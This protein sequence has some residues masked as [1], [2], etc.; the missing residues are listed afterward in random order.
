MPVYSSGS[1]YYPAFAQ[2]RRLW[3]WWAKNRQERK[4]AA[5]V[6]KT[7]ILLIWKVKL[8][9]RT[10]EKLDAIL[11]NRKAIFAASDLT[12]SK[13]KNNCVNKLFMGV[14]ILWA[15][16]ICPAGCK[17]ADNLPSV[18]HFRTHAS[19]ERI[20]KT[21]ISIKETYQE[22]SADIAGC[23]NPRVC[24]KIDS[25]YIFVVKTFMNYDIAVRLQLVKNIYLRIQHQYV[26]VRLRSACQRQKFRNWLL[27]KATL[28][29]SKNCRAERSIS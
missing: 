5:S 21:V 29:W 23:V 10:S 2:F 20:W 24:G 9:F 3:L 28:D 15:I 19:S 12:A 16:I 17:R 18:H 11:N 25:C 14:F 13:R 26:V 8:S 27:E 6:R 7:I 1:F 22:T 4:G